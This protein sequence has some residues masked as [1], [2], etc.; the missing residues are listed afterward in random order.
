M[1]NQERLKELFAL[2]D[3]M[4]AYYRVLGK[5]SFDM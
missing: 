2:L 4:E 5:V 3:E 1:T